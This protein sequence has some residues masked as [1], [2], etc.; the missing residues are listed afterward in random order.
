ML[1]KDLRVALF[2]LG[3]YFLPL[4]LYEKDGARRYKTDEVASM[5][6][7]HYLN[8]LVAIEYEALLSCLRGLLKVSLILLRSLGLVTTYLKCLSQLY[9]DVDRCATGT[10]KENCRI[11]STRT[12][13]LTSP[14]NQRRGDRFLF[15]CYLLQECGALFI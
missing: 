11:A 9:Y 8:Q 2:Y 7:A 4:L 5:E 1:G 3:Y 10:P 14:W 6:I 12:S 15:R 13:M